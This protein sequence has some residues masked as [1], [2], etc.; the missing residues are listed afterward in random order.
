MSKSHGLGNQPFAVGASHVAAR[1]GVDVATTPSAPGTVGSTGDTFVRPDGHAQQSHGADGWTKKIRDRVAKGLASISD[2]FIISA[3]INGTG[4]ALI[5]FA[6]GVPVDPK[7]LATFQ[8]VGTTIG[9]SYFP[10]KAMI[11]TKLSG[12]AAP[13]PAEP[14]NPDATD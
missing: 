2:P 1:H 9:A 13:P 6:F 10:L 3:L 8:V 11:Q 12:T 4:T 14:S 5:H 7:V